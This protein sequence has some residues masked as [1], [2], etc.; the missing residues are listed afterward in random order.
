MFPIN[1]LQLWDELKGIWYNNHRHMTLFIFLMIRKK[2]FQP[3]LLG[4]G[5]LTLTHSA[6]YL[7][8][9]TLCIK[10]CIYRSPVFTKYSF[11]KVKTAKHYHQLNIESK[12][13][14]WLVLKN[15]R[16][17]FNISLVW[18]DRYSGKL[19]TNLKKNDLVQT[20]LI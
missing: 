3:D 9:L 5:T 20:P 12:I 11:I 19:H 17:N 7:N 1:E 16:D 6:L 8:S 2:C 4:R 18:I 10:S 15:E 14:T 13:W